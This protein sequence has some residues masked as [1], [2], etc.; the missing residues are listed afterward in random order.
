MTTLADRVVTLLQ[1]DATLTALVSTRIYPEDIRIA[2]P[3]AYPETRTATGFWLPTVCVDDAGGPAAP[4][5]PSGSYADLLRVWIFAESN[6][7]V[8]MDQITKRVIV[9]LH[10]W[11]DTTTRALLT[12][13]S[14]TGFQ[15][16]PAPQ[17]GALDSITFGVSGIHIGINS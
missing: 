16:D 12:Y 11:Q 3:I 9:L 13:G 14:R 15:P 10:R 2:G 4:L 17:T 7:R 8:V 6:A 5:G 1:A